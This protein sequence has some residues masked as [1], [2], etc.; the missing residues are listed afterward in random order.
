MGDL[1]RIAYRDR[2]GQITPSCNVRE[3]AI[4]GEKARITVIKQTKNDVE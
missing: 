3:T 4:V 2:P 1:S